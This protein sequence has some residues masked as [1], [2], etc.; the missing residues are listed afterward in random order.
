MVG[1]LTVVELL[2]D[3]GALVLEVTGDCTGVA[4]G[5][6]VTGIPPPLELLPP[7]P[8]Q[9][10]MPTAIAA[11]IKL[12]PTRRRIRTPVYSDI[13]L[14]DSET[15]WVIPRCFVLFT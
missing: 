6:V 14:Q 12:K 9:A 11:T 15:T 2:V 10:A 13:D 4:L 3:N 5:W 1:R 7:P 8:P